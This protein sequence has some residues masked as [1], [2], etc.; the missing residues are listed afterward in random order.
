M[1]GVVGWSTE[2]G[3]TGGGL[4]GPQATRRRGRTQS[5][6]KSPRRSLCLCVGRELVSRVSLY[7]MFYLKTTDA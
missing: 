2:V 1:A 4:A 5:P 7:A 6:S 3:M